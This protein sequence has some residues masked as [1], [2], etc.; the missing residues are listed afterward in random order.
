MCPKRILIILL[1]LTLG[2]T[3]QVSWAS[4]VKPAYASPDGRQVPS[5]S[6][7]FFFTPSF[8]LPIS[9][10]PAQSEMRA[11]EFTAVLPPCSGSQEACISKVEYQLNGDTWLR[12]SA[13]PDEGQRA[14][15]GGYLNGANNWVLQ[16]S[17]TFKEDLTIGRPEGATAR[18]WKFSQAPHAASDSYQVAVQFKGNVSSEGKFETTSFSAEVIPAT[19]IP[20]N[21]QT[22]VQP[23][24]WEER[25]QYSQDGYC[26]TIY[27]FPENLNVRVTVK[28]GA[29]LEKVQG[30]F[31][32]RLKDAS[33]K[34]DSTSKNIE[35]QGAPL[36][37]PSAAIRPL[38]YAEIPRSYEGAPEADVIATQNSGPTGTA[39][40]GDANNDAILRNFI[41]MTPDILP[42]ATG[43]NTIWKISSMKTPEDKG[44]L[45]PGIVNGIVI[46][47]ATVY[48]ASAPTWSPQKS[49][50]DFKVAATHYDSRGEIFK[51]YYKM[52]VSE[53]VAQC[54][55][56]DDFSKGS[57]SISITNQDGSPDIAT[58]NLGVRDGW[59]NF[60]AAGFTFSAPTISAIIKKAPKVVAT[61]TP[62][63]IATPTPTPNIRTITCVAKDKKK[64]VK[65]INPQCPK[66]FKKK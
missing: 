13:G 48:N 20:G 51:G 15:K 5:G 34:V 65:G 61:P 25:A 22:C 63:P 55:W 4:D 66:G 38:K 8:L 12:A 30:W 21:A 32:G 7:Q 50:L 31:D 3:T 10:Q 17:S 19:R 24:I 47:N 1:S 9:Y 14:L 54:Y 46:T 59:M 23:S 53:K 58:T 40:M 42:N 44:C 56:G 36:T 60:D 41:T 37:V 28:L 18:M 29:F 35:I 26:K 49:S 52:L 6:W 27:D 45:R 64:I 33:V 57:A 62:T 39:G 16:S 2:A 43:E 11:R